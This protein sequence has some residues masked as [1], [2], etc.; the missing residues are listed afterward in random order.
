MAPGCVAG[1]ICLNGDP[2][3]VDEGGTVTMNGYLTDPELSQGQV[4][5]AWGDG[6]T[7]TESYPCEGPSCHFS[8]TPTY[9]PVGTCINPPTGPPTCPLRMFFRFTHTY[10]DDKAGGDD[11]YTITVTADDGQQTSKDTEAFVRNVAPQLELV[12]DA[13]VSVEAGKPVTV[14]ARLV[15]PGSDPRVVRIDWG[16]GSEPETAGLSC[17]VGLTDCQHYATH[18]FTSASATPYT[19]TLFTQDGDG[20]NDTETVVVTV[21]G[22]LPPAAA[23]D[24]VQVDEDDVLEVPAPGLL[25][26][27]TDGDGD[28]VTLVS[29]STPEHGTLATEADGSW[30]FT[31]DADFHGETSFTYTV[32]AD[33]VQ[34][35]GEVTITV[36]P[37]NDAPTAV[38]R[39]ATT[40]E[41]HSVTITPQMAD[42]DG[43]ALTPQVVAGPSHG[44]ATVVAGKLVYT[45][46]AD[47]YGSDSFTYRASD[48]TATSSPATV[49]VTVDAVG[50][51]PQVAALGDVSAVY[52][53]AITPIAVTATDADSV[54]L[55]Y[56]ATG[57]PSGLSIATTPSGATI[58]GK[59][60]AAPGRY[61]VTVRVCDSDDQCGTEPFDVVVAA[62]QAVVLWSA[63]NPV[64]VAVGKTGAPATTLTARISD[65]GDGAFGDV[66]R[67]T[68]QTVQA[69]AT[70]VGGGTATSCP[71][72]IVRRTPATATTPGS[73]DVSCTI[74][75]GL[76]ADV[77]ELTVSVTGSFAGSDSGLLG[78][79]DAKTRGAS[80]AGSV[81]LGNGNTLSFGLVASGEGKKLKGQ[82]E[83]IERTPAGA[84]V[85][86]VKGVTLSSLS[87]STGS[88]RT[89]VLNGKAVV[90]GVGNY[91]YVLTVTD[92]ATDT[93]ALKV[94]APSGAPAVP[95]LTFAARS[96]RTGGSIT[97][98]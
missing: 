24:E 74:P 11:K 33:G 58:S 48:G 47:F 78:V 13:E 81:L 45:P 95:S 43:D 93:L 86:R 60:T 17:D 42:V 9:S 19:V 84:I 34:D 52:S 30:T 26:L 65:T 51:A 75:A 63:T 62:E 83:L 4:R 28:T 23:D 44:S 91:S 39:S 7:T 90:N 70:P 22:D 67:I 53:D 96:V 64:S 16:D 69:S 55:T 85:N 40:S 32:A 41:D 2:R 3:D 8:L 88:P 25:G 98:T 57:L 87:V 76:K 29:T 54:S 97:V 61:P 92:A 49:S 10:A 14:A 36:N 6:Q 80:G 72:T 89:A 77:Y 82:V 5:I 66:T 73:V 46:A 21:F 37:V 71:V 79:F 27:V 1:E 56:S 50:D 18:T 31:P 20:G 35:T 12:S 38:D 68:A 15:D 59:V 94:T